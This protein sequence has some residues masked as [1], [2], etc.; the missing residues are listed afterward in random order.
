MTTTL[1]PPTLG[2]VIYDV[3]TAGGARFTRMVRTGPEHFCQGPNPVPAEHI[4][5]FT[6]K[7]ARFTRRGRTFIPADA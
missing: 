4:T 2:T 3:E 6:H 7:G 1:P 5:A